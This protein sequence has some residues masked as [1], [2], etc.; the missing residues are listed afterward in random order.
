MSWDDYHLNAPFFC[1]PLPVMRG[2]VSAVC[3]RREALDAEF[4]ASCV[5]SGASAVAEK[6]L[7]EM[8]LCSSA[9]GIPF[10]S[11][12]KAY[13]NFAPYANG[14]SSC[15]SFM[16][17]FDAF[18]CETLGE[19]EG[20][21]GYGHHAFTDSAGTRTYGSQEA[22]ASA[23]QEPLIAPHSFDSS[24]SDA[25]SDFR[26]ALNAAWASQRTRMLKVLRYVGVESGGFAMRRADMDGLAYGAT[27]QGAYNAIRGW[28]FSETAFGGWRTPLECRAE[29]HY[30]AWDV[31]EERWAITSSTEVT[32][33]IPVFDGCPETSAARLSFDAVDL[34]ERDGEG[35]I[36]E[37]S[38]DTFVFDPLCAGVSS[39]ANTLI[40]SGGSFASW[41]Y[42][43][44]S[45][46]GG[47]DTPTG[48]YVR[49]W[50]A[51]NVKIIYD[52][53]SFFNFKQ[54]E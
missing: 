12:Q 43:S 14:F 51:Q 23:L 26:V 15:Y 34:R 18:L 30:N 17:M 21:G 6:V 13:L 24:A 3:E 46:L 38:A 44:A 32:R 54:G 52:Y 48:S 5:S 42:G 31:P 40:L 25:D 53:E 37:E 1:T 49:G 2:L 29:Y 39:G 45:A 20:H 8:L 35:V 50:Q 33:I 28:T 11:L 10:R 7:A 41:G 9:G 16:H 19:F 36:I 47:P 22:L 4:H 27:P